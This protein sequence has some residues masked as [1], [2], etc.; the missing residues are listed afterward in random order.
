MMAETGELGLSLRDI[1]RHGA[2]PF[3]LSFCL[4]PSLSL[5][6]LLRA[7]AWLCGGVHACGWVGVGG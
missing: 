4:P 3:Y 7:G 2:P 6:R 5:A 1:M